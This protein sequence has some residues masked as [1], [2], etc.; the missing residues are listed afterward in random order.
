MKPILARLPAAVA[1][2]AILAAPTAAT[3][4]IRC[5]GP[6]QIVQGNHL[7]TPYCG[8]GYLAKVARSYGSSVSAHTIRQNPNKKQEICQW[9][10]H[11][12]RIS[13]ICAGYR[14]DGFGTG[15][16]H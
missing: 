7:A 12:T 5:E 13:D 8:D 16:R 14:T 9:I 2:A 6:Y 15:G 4:K 1:A 11:D 3:A 10:G